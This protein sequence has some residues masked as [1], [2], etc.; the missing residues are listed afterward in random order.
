MALTSTIVPYDPD[1]LKLYQVEASALS[2]LFSDELLAVH[3]VGST[4]IPGIVAKPEI[5]IFVVLRSVDGIHAFDDGME[6]LGYRVR[7]EGPEGGRFYYSKNVDGKRTHKVHAAAAGHPTLC[8]TLLFRDYLRRNSER[9]E[10]YGRLKLK[11]EAENSGGMAEYLE[12]K[13]PFIQETIRMARAE[14]YE[15]PGE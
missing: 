6:A 2:E 11:L 12:G 15:P 14:G 5:D 9:A 10:A 7:G 4:S 8:E 3:H 13:G 1:W